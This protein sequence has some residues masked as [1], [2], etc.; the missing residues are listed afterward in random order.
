MI[1]KTSSRKLVALAISGTVLVMGGAAFATEHEV[2]EPVADTPTDEV[3]DDTPVDD[4]TDDTTDDVTDDTT[5][6]TTDAEAETT[7]A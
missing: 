3:V 2:D 1:L 7:G 5:D 4:T 6:D